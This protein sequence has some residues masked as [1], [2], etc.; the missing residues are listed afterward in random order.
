MM[1]AAA[2]VYAVFDE[3]RRDALNRVPVPRALPSELARA[4]RLSTRSARARVR[5]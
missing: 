4:R 3:D 1:P 2:L 5:S